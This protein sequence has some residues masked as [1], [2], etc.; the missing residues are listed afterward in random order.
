MDKLLMIATYAFVL[1]LDGSH[2][3]EPI[4][5]Y[6]AFSRP[7]SDGDIRA[8]QQRHHQGTTCQRCL[9]INFSMSMGRVHE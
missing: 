1:C 4:D 9:Q 7:F 2:F 3:V 6:H 8:R 5:S